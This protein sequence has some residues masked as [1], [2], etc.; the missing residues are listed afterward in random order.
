MPMIPI[1]T[2]KSGAG[3]IFSLWYCELSGPFLHMHFFIEE[4]KYKSSIFA[5]VNECILGVLVVGCRYGLGILTLYKLYWSS[6]TLV[7]LKLS[8]YVVK[9][10]F[11]FN[12]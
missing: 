3:L 7:I 9:L 5:I 6:E 12:Q 8:C 1:T 2:W 11:I 10:S 4:S